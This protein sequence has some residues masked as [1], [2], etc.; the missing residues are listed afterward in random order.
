MEDGRG[1]ME[2][3]ALNPLREKREDRREQKMPGL[4]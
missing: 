4:G 1:K 2:A 3:T